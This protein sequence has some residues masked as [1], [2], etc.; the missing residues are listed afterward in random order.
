MHVCLPRCLSVGRCTYCF[1]MKGVDKRFQSFQILI[2]PI[3][4]LAFE[5]SN[6]VKMISK[7]SPSLAPITKK[8]TKTRTR[9]LRVPLYSTMHCTSSC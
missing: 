5:K 9:Y 7:I 1:L 3:T 4:F 8:E 2:I 6:P